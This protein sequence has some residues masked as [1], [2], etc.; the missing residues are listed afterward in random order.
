MGG[1]P[2][3]A[4]PEEFD[5]GKNCIILIPTDGALVAVRIPY[6]LHTSCSILLPDLISEF[7]CIRVPN[8]MRKFFVIIP[9][10]VYHEGFWASHQQIWG[11]SGWYEVFKVFNVFYKYVIIRTYKYT[12]KY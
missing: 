10:V 11:Q 5:T 12:A 3:Q 6:I 1:G 2:R 4:D 9:K 8:D 7:S